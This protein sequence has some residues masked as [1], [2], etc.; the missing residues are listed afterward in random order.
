MVLVQVPPRQLWP[1]EQWLPQLPQSLSSLEELISETQLPMH[2]VTGCAGAGASPPSLGRGGTAVST[3]ATI[4]RIVDEMDALAA[5][6]P[7]PFLS[8]WTGER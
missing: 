8:G 6:G 2:E 4:I 5:S 3:A 1:V 7:R